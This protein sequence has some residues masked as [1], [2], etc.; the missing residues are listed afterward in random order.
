MELISLPTAINILKSKIV[1]Q[2][3]AIKTLCLTISKHI[4]KSMLDINNIRTDLQNSANLLLYGPTGVG[5]TYLLS[6]VAQVY[7]IPILFLNGPSIVAEGWTGKNMRQYIN[8]HCWQCN[9]FQYSI[10]VIDEFDKL[11][12]PISSS[13]HDNVSEIIQAS[14]LAFIEGIKYEYSK[15]LPSLKISIDTSKFLFLFSGAFTEL[16]KKQKGAI[17]FSD[18]GYLDDTTIYEQILKFGVI[19]ELA[20]RIRNICELP[21]HTKESLVNLFILPSWHFNKWLEVLEKL[22]YQISKPQYLQLKDQLIEKA[23]EKNLG[24]RGLIQ[25]CEIL[26]NNLIYENMDLF[27]KDNIKKSFGIK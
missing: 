14:L 13:E 4:L 18:K 20:G 16:Q 5:K 6:E 1:G 26:I 9:N 12:R 2:D 17:G 15:E 11:C 7:N 22:G 19:P 3:E 10:I 27:S 8:E 23:L 21:H 25:E 24:V